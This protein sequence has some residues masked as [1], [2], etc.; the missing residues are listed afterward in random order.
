M[1]ISYFSYQSFAVYLF[2][3]PPSLDQLMTDFYHKPVSTVPR[4]TPNAL[5]RAQTFVMPTIPAT[6]SGVTTTALPFL[7][8]GK[9][10]SIDSVVSFARQLQVSALQK[11]GALVIREPSKHEGVAEDEPNEDI[12]TQS[13]PSQDPTTVGTSSW[14]APPPF[15]PYVDAL[16]DD[17]GWDDSFHFPAWTSS[18]LLKDTIP[19][20][21]AL[22]HHLYVAD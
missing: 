12:P 20:F 18:P 13:L 5:Y 15:P 9:G 19:Q 22:D 7:Y 6:S 4:E 16:H 8:K 3:L 11:D 17:N 21:L 14:S 10:I 2:K 1:F